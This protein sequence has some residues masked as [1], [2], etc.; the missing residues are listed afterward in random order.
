MSAMCPIPRHMSWFPRVVRGGNHDI[1]WY[2]IRQTEH[3]Q[4]PLGHW[5][6]N[7]LLFGSN[8]PA[9]NCEQTSETE[10][11]QMHHANTIECFFFPLIISYIY[12]YHTIF[13][14]FL[15]IWH[16]AIGSMYGIYAN[17]TGIYWW[18]PWHTIYSSTMDPLGLLNTAMAR[19][20]RDDFKPPRLAQA[21]AGQTCVALEKKRSWCSPSGD[22]WYMWNMY[23]YNICWTLLDYLI[24]ALYFNEIS[25]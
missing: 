14:H 17:M 25:M 5:T 13:I 11:L 4:V 19:T 21:A 23:I 20:G 6:A 12:I 8:L 7:V 9:V 24:H 16:N 15:L 1:H 2:S 22:I 18:D 10:T 3:V